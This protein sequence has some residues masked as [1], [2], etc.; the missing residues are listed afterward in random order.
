MT[1]KQFR[2]ARVR[3]GY[4]QTK[5]AEVLQPRRMTIS[6]YEA[7]TWEVPLSVEMA[8]NQLG[9]AQIP[10]IGMAAAGAPI[11]P[12]TQAE[13]IAVLPPLLRGGGD[14]RAACQRQVHA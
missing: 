12:I 7:G 8:L 6:R 9:S 3:V 14:L 1:A 11:E 4:T 10:M 2:Q 13:L 5:L